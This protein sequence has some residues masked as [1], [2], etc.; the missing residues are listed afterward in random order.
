M[1]VPRFDPDRIFVSGE[2]QSPGAYAVPEGT[3]VLEALT[4]AGGPTPDAALNRVRIL[5]IVD[6]VQETFNV[7]LEDIVEPRDTI[8]VRPRFF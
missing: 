2:V 6:G 8:M 4:L 7:E 5:R 3:T 1:F